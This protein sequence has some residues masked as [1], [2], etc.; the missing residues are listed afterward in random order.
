MNAL[1][2]GKAITG[3]SAFVLPAANP[4]RRL[5]STQARFQR[6]RRRTFGQGDVRSIGVSVGEAPRRS[7][8]P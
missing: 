2:V 3:L 7:E 8:V 5:R 4:G 1:T 6:T